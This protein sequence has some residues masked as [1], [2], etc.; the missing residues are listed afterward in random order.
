MKFSGSVV[1]EQGQTFGIIRVKS[2]VLN[3]SSE[4]EDIIEFGRRA[5]G[6][7]P[8]ILFDDKRFYGRPDIVSFLT[9]IHPSRIPWKEYTID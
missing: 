5:F 4:R 1:T 7:M 2:H 9:R 6:N 3:N 8:I